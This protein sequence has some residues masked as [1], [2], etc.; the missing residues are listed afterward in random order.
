MRLSKPQKLEISILMPCLNEEKT[1]GQMVQHA[2]SAIKRIGVS[3]EVVISDNG[4]SDRSAA[5]AT[6]AGARVVVTNE[7]GYGNA[8]RFGIDHCRGNYVVILD[9]DGSYDLDSLELFLERL[10]S[11]YDLVMGDRFKRKLKAGSMP[12]KNRYIGNPLLSLISRVLFKSKISDFH[13]GIRGFSRKKILELN[14]QSRG[15]EFATE[16]IAR[17][18][19]AKLKISEVPVTLSPDG[20]N[21]P[22]HLNPWRDGWRH[23]R[24]MLIFSPNWLFLFP[25]LFFLVLNTVLMGVILASGSIVLG[26]AHFS[27][28]TM[29]YL[30]F[31]NVL[32]FQ[33]I[34]FYFLAKH[35]AEERG[36]LP[37]DRTVQKVVSILGHQYSSL[38]SI[39]GV[40]ISMAVLASQFFSWANSGFG[41]MDPGEYV[42][43]TACA[44]NLLV[45]GTQIFL[46]SFYL[47]LLEFKRSR[48][49]ELED[50]N[51][52]DNA[53]LK[54][55]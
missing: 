8:L 11:G 50:N 13:C 34:I 22:S 51:S 23:L 21:R 39:I 30:S 46:A 49:V 27:T 31:F 28:H 52:N 54:S 48:P 19:I 16:L 24:F 37:P 33:M 20:R 5:I 15:M 43:I 26:P 17:A 9:S 41:T 32:S 3:G 2:L 25:G 18:E 53:Y 29:L 38:Y 14:L 55:A 4:S 6:N 12:W 7:K 47:G 1:V 44:G 35:S 36:I 42:P 45:V 10:R 40:L